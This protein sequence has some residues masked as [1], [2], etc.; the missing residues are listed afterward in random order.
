VVADSG[1]GRWTA[2]ESINLGVPTPVMT[3][4]LMSRFASQGKGDYANQMLAMMRKGFGGHAVKVKSRVGAHPVA[5]Q[6]KESF[7]QE[8]PCRRAT[9]SSLAPPAIWPP[10]SCCRRCT[11]WNWPAN[12]RRAQFRRLR[13]ARVGRCQLARQRQSP[14]GQKVKAEGAAAGTLRQRF[15]YARRVGRPA[16]L[17]DLKETLAK[18]KLGVCSNV[19]FYLAIKPNDFPAVIKNLDG[20]G[21]SKPRGC[22]ASWWRN[23]SASTSSRRR[24]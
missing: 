9:S 22:I 20:A 12:C 19:V 4:A 11:G 21:L 15:D 3:L 23:R 14:V 5:S 16:G 24:C 1:E 6:T 7:D 18:P 8:T 13:S 17:Q 10:T 2:L